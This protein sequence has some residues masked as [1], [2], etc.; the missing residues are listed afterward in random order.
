MQAR[1]VM[2][3]EVITV[4]P[5]D[6]VADLAK[7]LLEHGISGAPV[8]DGDKLVGIVSEGDLVRRAE[9]G[10]AKRRRNWWLQLFTSDQTLAREYVKSHARR[11][12]DLM[13]KDVVTVKEDTDLSEIAHLMEKKRVKRIPVV[14]GG[15]VVG[16]VSRADILRKL[17]AHEKAPM[18]QAP[19]DTALREKI[20]REIRSQGWKNPIALSVTVTNGVVDLWGV[21][22]ND[23][24]RDTIRVAAES[25]DGVEKVQDNRQ[26][27]RM[28][29]PG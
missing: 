8:V 6:T 5:D 2:T 7:T 14:R 13:V 17:A 19:D 22:R 1:D 12:R 26:R 20:N 15:K 9:V 29:Y 16:I 23:E 18:E 24:E 11:V 27:V 4:G 10:T 3:A 21:Y 25:I 28:P